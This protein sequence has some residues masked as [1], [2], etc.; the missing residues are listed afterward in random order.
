M[1]VGITTVHSDA[2]HRLVSDVLAAFI[3]KD[4]AK[5]GRHM[6]D[7]SNHM[8]RAQG[9]KAL[10]E[11][12]F[13]RK[14]ELIT[15]AASGKDYFMQHL[16]NYITYICNAAS[17]HHVMLNQ[18]FISSALAVKVQEGIALALDP[19]VQISKVAIPIIMEGELRHGRAGERARELLPTFDSVREWLTGKK[20]IRYQVMSDDDPQGK[21][22]VVVYSPGQQ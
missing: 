13:V 18:A 6:I 5:A 15:I 20:T 14:I 17:T 22:R 7:S 16:G 21:E 2:D 8:L 10:H 11:E 19:S 1:D 9:D 4:G 3:R 12:D